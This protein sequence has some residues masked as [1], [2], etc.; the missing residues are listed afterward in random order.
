[1]MEACFV[2]RMN[3]AL[4]MHSHQKSVKGR[5]STS[6]PYGHGELWVTRQ[7]QALSNVDARYRA[8]RSGSIEAVPG[9]MS[10]YDLPR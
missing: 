10:L 7:P 2:E 9:C 5:R 8:Q 1:M 3:R 6:P 4:W